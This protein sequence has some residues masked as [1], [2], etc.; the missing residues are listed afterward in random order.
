MKLS[1]IMSRN[2]K[3]LGP[4]ANLLEAAQC[5]KDMDIGAVPVCANNRIEGFVTDRDIIVRAIAEGKNPN[6]CKVSDV[7]STD[8][9]W[10]FEDEDVEAAGKKMESNQVRRLLVLDRNKKLTGIVSIGDIARAQHG[11]AFSGEVLEQ[12]SQPSPQPTA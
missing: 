7:M 4:D 1:E 5:M 6:E 11:G 10:C 3:V 9:Q 2:V 12:V 8:I